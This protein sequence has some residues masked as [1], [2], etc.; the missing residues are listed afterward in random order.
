MTDSEL[1]SK[2]EAMRIAECGE[3]WR[4]FVQGIM[5]H[6]KKPEGLSIPQAMLTKLAIMDLLYDSYIEGMHNAAQASAFYGRGQE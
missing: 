3:D 5:S 6:K 4:E 1:I 2:V